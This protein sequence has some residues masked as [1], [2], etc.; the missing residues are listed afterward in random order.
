MFNDWSW[1]LPVAC[2]MSV[3]YISLTLNHSTEWGLEKEMAAHS[4]ILAWRIL[5]TEEPGGLLSVGS[6]RVRHGWSDLACMHALEKELATHSS[7]LAWRIPETEEPG[8]LP[9]MGWH[10]V[11]HEWNDLAVAAFIFTEFFLVYFINYWER[12]VE[13]STY[14]YLSIFSF[15]FFVLLPVLQNSAFRS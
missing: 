3:D 7:I 6:H 8:G 15:L 13:I 2:L 5:W 11:G 4:S 9:S 14:N 1:G 12:F 10:R